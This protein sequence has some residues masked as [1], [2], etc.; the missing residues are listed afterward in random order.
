M[1]WNRRPR[2]RAR[3]VL[4]RAVACALVLASIAACDSETMPGSTEPPAGYVVTPHGL[5]HGSC[6]G[7][8]AAGERISAAGLLVRANGA[9]EQLAACPFPRLNAHTLEPIVHGDDFLPT[10]SGWIEASYWTSPAALGFLRAVFTVPSLP[11]ST[12]GTV[13][14]FPGAEPGDGSTILQPVLQY[15]SSA[16]GG[17]DSWTAAS[18]FC[19]PAGWSFYSTPIE[20]NAGDTLFGTMTAACSDSA[21]DWTITTADLTQGISTTLQADDV[22]S[23]FTCAYGGV[24]ES[25]AVSECSQYPAAG[26]ITFSDIVL[27]DEDGNSLE[28]AWSTFVNSGTPECAYGVETTTA[29]TTLSY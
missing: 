21:C 4:G 10:T 7:A 6:V 25:Y 14:F 19:C 23:P 28:P 16:A 17:G 2:P 12:G 27:E 22:T 15:G 8:I 18:W 1:L 29:T 3:A 13:F 11:E 9:R 24:L 26:T 20:V 5:V